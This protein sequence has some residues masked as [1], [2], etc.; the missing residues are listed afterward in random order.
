MATRGARPKPAA[1]RVVDGTT[2]VTRAVS[3]SLVA[4]LTA[5]GLD[6]YFAQPLKAATPGFVI[7]QSANLGLAGAQ[8]VGFPGARFP[9]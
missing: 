3:A 6:G 7:E 1:L 4:D 5:A 2:N 9:P 8:Q